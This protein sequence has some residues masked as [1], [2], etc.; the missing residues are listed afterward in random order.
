MRL[1]TANGFAM[2]SISRAHRA[3]CVT[4]IGVLLESV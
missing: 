3:D 1:D 4:A 2:P